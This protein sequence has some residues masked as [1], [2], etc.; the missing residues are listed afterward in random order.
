M[1]H[2]DQPTSTRKPYARTW[3]AS[4]PDQKRIASVIEERTTLTEEQIKPLFLEA[5]TKD[6][7]YAVDS[8]IIH[9]IKDVEIPP[10]SP[11]IA[12]VFQR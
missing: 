4:G 8:G 3:E 7:A 6:A 9:E 5:Q 12:L 11:V 10:G 2:R 1:A